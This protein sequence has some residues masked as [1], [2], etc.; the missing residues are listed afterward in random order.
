MN[1]GRGEAVDSSDNLSGGRHLNRLLKTLKRIHSRHRR[2]WNRLLL[3]SFII[4]SVA[5]GVGACSNEPPDPHHPGLA[6]LCE[7]SGS[8]FVQPVGGD[9]V[10]H[11]TDEAPQS[12]AGDWNVSTLE[13]EALDPTKMDE[14][15]LAV[16]DGTFTGIDGILIARNGKLVLEAYFDGFDREARHNIRSAFKSF[17]STFAGIAIDRELLAGIDQP[18][19]EL[20]SDRWGRL[21]NSDERKN[22]ITLEHLLTMTPGFELRPG[23]DD[24]EDWYQFALEQ[25]LAYEPGTR[26]RYDDGNSML[27]GGAVA[28]AAGESLPEFA[29]KMLFDPLGISDYCWTLTPAGQPMTDG[30]FYM[31]PR[32]FAKLGQ[33]Y[34]NLGE[35]NGKQIVSK[36][37]VRKSTSIHVPLPPPN[38][39]KLHQ[40]YGYHWWVRRLNAEDDKRFEM[41]SASGGSQKMAVFPNLRLVAVFTGSRYYGRSAHQ[42]PWLLLE[43]YILPALLDVK[44]ARLPKFG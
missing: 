17:T 3:R 28:L 22:H 34:L 1:W 43:R 5:I 36:S 12:V 23:L 31:R 21:A 16:Q 8:S 30:S 26:F 4:V 25:P 10:L 33:L 6:K 13:M 19:S 11:G 7:P 29:K 20:F 24:A 27:I 44:G 15:L 14:M 39:R 41:Y 35:W 32:D 40:D 18:I 37:W 42:Q 9:P 38:K 2:K